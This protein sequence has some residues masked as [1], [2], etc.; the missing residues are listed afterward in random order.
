MATLNGM[1]LVGTAVN[2]PHGELVI[3]LLDY[4]TTLLPRILE[5]RVDGVYDTGLSATDIYHAAA[6]LT[7]RSGVTGWI[8]DFQPI[9]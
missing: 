6:K 5:K 9:I 2:I 7:A 3:F 1:G 8:E 4:G